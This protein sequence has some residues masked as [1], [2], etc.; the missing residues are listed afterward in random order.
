MS[1]TK[2]LI[3]NIEKIKTKTETVVEKNA[4]GDETSRRL[5][6]V[7]MLRADVPASALSGIHELM[8]LGA[9]VSMIIGSAQGVL[10][11]SEKVGALA[12]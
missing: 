2:V 12:E 5:V 3:T 11:I 8:K 1:E 9:P 4:E 6:T 7:I 10:E